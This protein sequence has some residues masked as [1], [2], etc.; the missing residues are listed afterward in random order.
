MTSVHKKLN[1]LFGT[2]I[3]VIRQKE[4]TSYYSSEYKLPMIVVEN[5]K[6]ALSKPKVRF[7]RAEIDDPFRKY[8][9]KDYEP[10]QYSVEDYQLMK[11]HGL[12]PG[13]NAPA[14]HHKSSMEE[15]GTTFYHINMTPQDIVLN[16]GV[17]LVLE[18]WCYY[19]ANNPAI[20]KLYVLTGNIPDS[21]TTKIDTLDVNIPPFM[22]KIV[23][24]TSKRN[25]GH[26]YMACFLYPNKPIIP[27]N[28]TTDLQ[29]YLIT[30]EKLS[31]ISGLN[32]QSIV[33]FII[34]K[35][36]IDKGMNTNRAK[37]TK[38]QKQK[39]K[40]GRT[41]KSNIDESNIDESNSNANSND[42]T[43][44]RFLGEILKGGIHYELNSQL[45]KSMT[46]ATYFGL[47]INSTSLDE[48]EKHWQ[49]YV[50]KNEKEKL[51][52]SLEYHREYYDLSKERI[53]AN[54]AKSDT[55]L[56]MD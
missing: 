49:D 36:N 3:D 51:N 7:V 41:L 56:Y 17:W 52:R 9:K 13:H 44:I 18:Q 29:K 21:K 15:W 46:N 53:I 54:T 2:N 42:K 14:G 1:K 8:N 37:L 26:M 11:K 32:I 12:S 25:P 55:S 47:L 31:D 43:N 35:Y 45:K 6:G 19:I 40:K 38:K 5:L 10:D 16:A 4:Y 22:Y 30:V 20:N 24:A 34:K 27:T 48:L 50:K 33:D 23:I 39:G 28:D